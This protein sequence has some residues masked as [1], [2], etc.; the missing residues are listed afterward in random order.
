MARSNKAKKAGAGSAAARSTRA[1]DNPASTGAG[2]LQ[3]EHYPPPQQPPIDIGLRLAGT[4]PPFATEF[5]GI[6]P[7]SPE[8][9]KEQYM[10]DLAFNE[11]P[12]TVVIPKSTERNAPN[13]VPCAV[14]GFGPE[15]WDERSKR[16][17]NFDGWLPV[18]RV[19][20]VKRK[21]LEVL[22]RSR[23]DEY[24]TR[25]VNPTPLANQ[26]GFVLECDTMQV[27]PFQVRW[28]GDP[29]GPE[30]YRRIMTDA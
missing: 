25:E 30:W 23:R 6:T 11:H 15:V 8:E 3:P 20:T 29:G 13:F 5:E 1:I 12:V 14:N 9:A 2:Q 22:A 24:R 10:K 17:L 16:W 27:A 19:L 7:M 4:A 26:D 28:D 21:Y 18:S